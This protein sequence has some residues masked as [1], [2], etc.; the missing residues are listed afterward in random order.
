MRDDLTMEFIILSRDWLTF[1]SRLM[2]LKWT[3]V[4][5]MFVRLKL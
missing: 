5:Q 1:H 2:L 4:E 3:D